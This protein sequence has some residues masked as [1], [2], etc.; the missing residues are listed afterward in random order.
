MGLVRLTDSALPHIHGIIL[1]PGDSSRDVSA[2]LPSPDT[3]SYL[4]AL[5]VVTGHAL[6][7]VM[8]AAGKVV[9]VHSSIESLRA[10]N[11]AQLR[12]P[13]MASFKLSLLPFATGKLQNNIF[14][15][16]LCQSHCPM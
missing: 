9:A 2:A 5:Q 4:Q 10:N 13:S 7:L 16:L 6:A 12:I 1:P 15:A 3:E 14:A 8:V 11:F